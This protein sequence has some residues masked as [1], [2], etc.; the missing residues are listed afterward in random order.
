MSLLLALF[1]SS[2]LAGLVGAGITILFLY[3]P[4]LWRGVYYDTLGALGTAA[5]SRTSMPSQNSEE[6]ARI[7][8][9]GGI[10]YLGGGVLFA[11]FYGLVALIFIAGPFPPPDYTVAFGGG[12]EINFWYLLLGLVGGFGHGIFVTLITSFIVVEFHPVQAYR[13]EFSLVLSYLIGHTVY[14]VVVMFFQSQL[15]PLLL[16]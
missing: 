11:V 14:G 15:L 1:L 5:L 16:G 3:L 9:V 4:L 13:D 12:L 8:V 10:F 7:R 6:M 2:V